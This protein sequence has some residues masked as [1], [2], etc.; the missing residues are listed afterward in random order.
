MNSIESNSIGT[1]QQH[2]QF[3]EW[4][5]SELIAL[6]LFKGQLA[7]ITFMDYLPSRDVHFL[8]H[9]DDAIQQFLQ[10]RDSTRDSIA[11]LIYANYLLCAE[12]DDS[13]PTIT[14][15]HEVWQHIEPRAVFVVKRYKD[16]TIYIDIN[17][18]CDWET[19]HG[20]QL[21]FRKGE[22]LTRVSQIDGFITDAD[23]CGIPDKED[24]LL[25]GEPAPIATP[26]LD[27]PL[28]PSAIEETPE[29]DQEE[30]Q[31]EIESQEKS[32]FWKKVKEWWS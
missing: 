31:T 16:D 23:A 12:G 4:W 26:T 27:E 3:L 20:L 9:A 21:V 25:S 1:L 6:P 24:F 11:H 13:T 32:G 22:R 18:S 28:T 15:P 2:E 7:P 5:E 17:C 10:Q 8:D 19:E 30:H 29:E 14:S